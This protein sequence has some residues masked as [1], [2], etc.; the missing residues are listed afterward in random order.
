MYIIELKVIHNKQ[1]I[2]GDFRKLRKGEIF[3]YTL[4][5]KK[6][7]ERPTLSRRKKKNSNIHR[8]RNEPIIIRFNL[9]HMHFYYIFCQSHKKR[10]AK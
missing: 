1:H 3:R 4:A 7:L 2:I 6:P 9:L 5:Y 8:H 10:I